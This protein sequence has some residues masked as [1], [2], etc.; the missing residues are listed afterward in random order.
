MFLLKSLMLITYLSMFFR[1][2]TTTKVADIKCYTCGKLKL[3]TELETVEPC[4]GTCFTATT[5]NIILK[6]CA[7]KGE[8]TLKAIRNTTDVLIAT[9]PN[10]AK[11]TCCEKT[12]CNYTSF[13]TSTNFWIFIIVHTIYEQ[14]AWKL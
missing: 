7:V 5:H 10:T 9:L 12:L 13:M 2:T 4:D 3:C 11:L 8:C 1:T 6:G 14:L